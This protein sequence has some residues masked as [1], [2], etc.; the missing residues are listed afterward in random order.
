MT[1]PYEAARIKSSQN[2]Y[3]PESMQFGNFSLQV[4]PNSNISF[5][6]LSDLC[7]TKEQKC[8]LDNL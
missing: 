3:I 2:S 4:F 6:T 5:K 1:M 8:L 7:I